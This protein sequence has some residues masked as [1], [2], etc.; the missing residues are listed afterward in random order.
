MG[1]TF[2]RILIPSE[3]SSGEAADDAIGYIFVNEI[4]GLKNL[5]VLNDD[6]TIGTFDF[7]NVTDYKIG[8]E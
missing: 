5:I 2:K 1:T 6:G 3:T 4:T 7:P 8:K